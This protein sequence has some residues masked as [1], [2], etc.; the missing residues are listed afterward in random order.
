M[1]VNARAIVER[2]TPD[3]VQILLQTRW[4]DRAGLQYYVDVAGPAPG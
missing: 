3:G 4:V 2:R 1:Y